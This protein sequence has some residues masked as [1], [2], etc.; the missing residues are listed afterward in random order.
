M[1]TLQ[2][3][4]RIQ[5]FDGTELHEAPMVGQSGEFESFWLDEA[6]TL[7]KMHTMEI[8][9]YQPSSKM[10]VIWCV[11]AFDC[12]GEALFEFDIVE[13]QKKRYVVGYD[14]QELGFCLGTYE[15]EAELIVVR[16]LNQ[17]VAGMSLKLGNWLTDPKLLG[18]E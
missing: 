7:I 15:S 1:K 5:I 4:S 16:R 14:A 12:Q 17:E 6:L 18:K 8:R 11:G 3:L 13:Y 10:Q 9:H 2:E